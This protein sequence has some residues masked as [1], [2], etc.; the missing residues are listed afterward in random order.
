MYYTLHNSTKPE[1]GLCFTFTQPEQPPTSPPPPS[2]GCVINRTFLDV[3]SL[4]FI[5]SAI[6]IS[7][8][9]ILSAIMILGDPA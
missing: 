8:D 9:F 4:D 3:G 7:L 5:L 1:F 2:V 6:M